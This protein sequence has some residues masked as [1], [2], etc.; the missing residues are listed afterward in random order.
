[1]RSQFW[2]KA[3][4]TTG[5][6]PVFSA[7]LHLLNHPY[8]TVTTLPATRLDRAIGIE[9]AALPVYLSLWCYVSLA[10]L[11][12]LTGRKSSTTE[13]DGAAVCRRA[14]GI[15]VLADSGAACRDRLGPLSGQ[16]HF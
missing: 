12:M 4:G 8:F 16:W 10:P 1:M 6:G 7:Y 2:F 13:S 11:L 15:P 3:L 9:P 5:Y 14:A